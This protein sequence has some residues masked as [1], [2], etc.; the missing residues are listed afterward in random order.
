VTLVTTEIPGS[1]A[2]VRDP[3]TNSV[4]IFGGAIPHVDCNAVG[5][6]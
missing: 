3:I 4:N 2:E 6:F 1:I 5:L